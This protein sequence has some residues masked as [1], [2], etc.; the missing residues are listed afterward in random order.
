MQA[1]EASIYDDV[2]ED[3]AKVGVPIYRRRLSGSQKGS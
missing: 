1:H 3:D 2:H